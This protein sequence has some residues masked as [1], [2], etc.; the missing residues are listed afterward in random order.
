MMIFKNSW[1][2]IDLEMMA[3]VQS[4]DFDKMFS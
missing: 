3:G 4:V 2:F 1:C